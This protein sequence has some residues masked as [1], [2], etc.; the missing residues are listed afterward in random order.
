[1][2]KKSGLTWTGLL[3]LAL[4]LLAAGCG[5]DAGNG[6]PGGQNGANGT[7]DG[8]GGD[9]AAEEQPDAVTTASLVD[10]GEGF[11]RAVGENG[12]WIIAILN[13]VT[14]DR[15]AVVEGTFHNRNDPASE[16]YRKLALY[17]QDE[18]RNITANYTLTIPRLIVRS[19]NF[20]IQGGTVKGDV[21]VE[22]GGF[23]LH[24]TSTIDGNLIFASE[25]VKAAAAIDG[26]VTGSVDVD[27]NGEDTG[28]GAS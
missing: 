7:G 8:A 28:D 22:A 11:V 6:G 2:N 27:E 26:N 21:R 12:T 18:D 20:R 15:E 1:M 16:V 17:A 13:D 4:V 25:G 10:D 14:V 23:N 3:A 5:G 19:E 9:R 24:E